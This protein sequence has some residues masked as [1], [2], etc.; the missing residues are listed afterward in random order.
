MLTYIAR[1]LLALPIVMFFVSLIIFL[2]LS[3]LPPGTR[4]AAFVGQN[5]RA[6]GATQQL[7]EKHGLNDDIH[8]QWWNW[9]TNVAQGNLGFSQTQTMPVTEALASFLPAT[10]ELMMASIVPILVIGIWLGVL[11]AIHQNSW[12]DHISRLTSIVG[13]SLPTFIAGL[14]LLMVFYGMLGWVSDGRLSTQATLIVRSSDFISYTGMNTID[15]LLNGNAFVFWDALKHLILPATTIVIVVTAVIVR[16]MRS[17]MLNTLRED[18]IYAARAKGLK[19]NVVIYKHA[20]RNAMIP[21]LTTSGV[22]VAGLFLGFATAEIVFNFKGLGYLFITS[23]QQLDFPM[24]LGFA[25]FSSIVFVI[26]NLI[27]DV[28]YAIYDPRVSLD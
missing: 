11:A 9:M 19:E 23:A 4:V 15:G 20:R 3:M 14:L 28:L 13:W 5:P 6:L 27:V 21:V 24:V 17:S 26:I 12:I 8:I 10:L 7:I 22:I 1:R 18:Y 25:L 2:L 16:I